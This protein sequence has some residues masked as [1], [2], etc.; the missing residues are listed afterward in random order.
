MA[1]LNYFVYSRKQVL[2][3][4]IHNVHISWYAEFLRYFKIIDN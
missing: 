4:L 3:M 2:Q 1:I